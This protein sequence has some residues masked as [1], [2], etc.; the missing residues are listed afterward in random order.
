MGQIDTL[1][2]T[3]N[4]PINA[5]KSYT[6]EK[7]L[8]FLRNRVLFL[9]GSSVY[10]QYDSAASQNLYGIYEEKVSDPGVTSTAEATAFAR[11]IINRQSII[12][13]VFNIEIIDDNFTDG[14]YDIESIKPGDQVVVSTEFGDLGSNYWGEMIW[15]QAY[16]KYDIYTIGGIPATVRRINYKFDRVM[17][18]CAFNYQ[19]IAE[20]LNKTDQEVKELQ[21]ADAPTTP[22]EV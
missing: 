9:G 12:Q 1:A 16:W 17:L 22:T 18:E 7:N 5:V 11:R 8:G 10:N 20:L 13:T 3:H 14:G 21:F 19:N 15:G 4:I 2:T 6:V